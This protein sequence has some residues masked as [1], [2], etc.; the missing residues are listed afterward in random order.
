MTIEC[1]VA[2][3]LKLSH[4]PT[5]GYSCSADR[6]SELLMGKLITDPSLTIGQRFTQL[7]PQQ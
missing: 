6:T 1:H 4:H 3:G 2:F 7:I 5:D